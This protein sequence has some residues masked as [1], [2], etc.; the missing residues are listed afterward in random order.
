M[1]SVGLA[2][3]LSCPD[4]LGVDGRL[5]KST[6]NRQQTA[7]VFHEPREQEAF[8]MRQRDIQRWLGKGTGA[9]HRT[10]IT[11]FALH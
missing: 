4:I 7:R 3:L 5:P 1:K 11:P 10:A 9:A 6:S 2:G 8:G